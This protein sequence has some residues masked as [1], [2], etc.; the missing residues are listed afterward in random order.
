[1]PLMGSLYV[2]TSGLQTSQNTLNATAHNLSN[3]DTKGFVR[4]QVLLG[5]R[6]Y[7]TIKKGTVSISSQQI[8]LGVT[9]EKVR[10][11]RDYFL[12][13][14]YRKENGRAAFYS[15]NYEAMSEVE[16]LL[17]ELND[18]ASFNHAMTNFWSTLQE[19]AKTPDDTTVQRMLI[20]NAQSFLTNA[21]QV[22]QGLIDYQGELNIHIKEKVDRINELG[23]EIMRLNDEIRK[24]EVGGIE[25][26]NDFRD[27]RNQCLDELS[28][29]V[30]IE[31]DE[32]VYHSV[33]VRV[34]GND[35]VTADAI[36]TIELS[37]DAKTGFYT[38]Y[39][40]M[41]A[42]VR[43]DDKG[44]EYLDLSRAL[45]Y[46]T[47]KIVSSEAN[48]DIGQLRAM[49]YIR[50]DKIADYTDI[51]VK[52][53]VPERIAGED[54][55]TYAARVDE[56]QKEYAAYEK[57]VD[58]YNHTIAQSVC[59]N[60]QAEFDQ[61]IHNVVTTVNDIL[62][63]AWSDARERGEVYM[64]DDDGSPLQIFQK[65]ESAGY[66]IDENTGEWTYMR[67][68]TEDTEED[69]YHTETLYSIPNLIINPHLLREAGKMKFRLDDK[70]VDYETAKK[71]VDA[72]DSDIY[73]LNPNVTT[74]CSLNTYYTNL[75]SQVANSGSVYKNITD[76][77]NITVS[78]IDAA[79][80][81]IMGVSS[82]EELSNM[83]K[84]QNAFNAA[85]RYINVVDELL[86]HIIST[87]G[88]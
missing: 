43:Y 10:Q 36:N 41:N 31:Y 45:V 52:P 30:H 38:P 24:V 13:Q 76:A 77:Q 34:E 56:Y 58:K 42:I 49:L 70:T 22:Y 78:S 71:L 59:M 2:G 79:R 3:M 81:Q 46:D 16:D 87:L 60:V 69:N 53:E 64:A 11:V 6:L 86:E 72:F 19:L 48:T 8:G 40:K 51:P 12:D 80:E 50:G 84:F 67:E 61:L 29:L 55:L 39:W 5:D 54:D 65:K 21:Q 82:D 85:S 23:K 66:T 74:R 25:S 73:A 9:Y 35:F 27:A 14:S 68:A 20:Q 44:D 88:T 75:V 57:R 15:S 47:S 1:M 62:Y 83:I 63:Q 17:N 32:D 33:R 28:G 4:Q 37:T 18:D 26:A 7:N